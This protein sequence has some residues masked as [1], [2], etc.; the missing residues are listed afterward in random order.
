[1]GLAGVVGLTMQ[2]GS[3]WAWGPTWATVRVN[4]ERMIVRRGEGIEERLLFRMIA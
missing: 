4:R 3:C 2:A 1:M